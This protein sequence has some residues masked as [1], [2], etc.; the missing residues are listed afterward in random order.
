MLAGCPAEGLAQ[1]HSE[2]EQKGGNVSFHDYCLLN[3]VV[4]L[5]HA[6]SRHGSRERSMPKKEPSN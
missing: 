3:F 4:A 6:I 1:P 5:R 2:S